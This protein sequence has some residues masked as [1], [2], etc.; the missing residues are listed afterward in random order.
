M[1]RVT[2]AGLLDDGGKIVG[3]DI[4]ADSRSP[5]CPSGRSHGGRNVTT[6]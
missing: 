4:E 5:A 1:R 2:H 3:E 6:R